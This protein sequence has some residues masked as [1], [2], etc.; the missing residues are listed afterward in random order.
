MSE[1]NGTGTIVMVGTARGGFIFNREPGGTEWSMSGPSHRG[2]QVYHLILDP[3]DGQMYA[4]VNSIFWGPEISRSSD[5]GA[6]WTESSKEPRFKQ[7][8][9]ETV[10]AM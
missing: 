1:Q 7:G 3:R 6:T 2:S 10:E 5:I 9:G 4:A 8:S